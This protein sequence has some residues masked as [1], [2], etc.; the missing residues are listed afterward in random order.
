MSSF[1]TAGLDDYRKIGIGLSAGG[2][3]FQVLGVMLFFDKGLLAMGN[4]CSLLPSLPVA[5]AVVMAIYRTLADTVHRWRHA[6]H[7]RR[8]DI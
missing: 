2:L 5:V 7:R 1:F 6:H 8:E 4:V 3:L